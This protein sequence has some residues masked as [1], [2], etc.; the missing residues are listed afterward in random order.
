MSRIEIVG[1]GPAG[2]YVAT[3]LKRAMPTA[4]VRVTEQ[5][6]ADATHG[7]GV[8]FSDRA[9]SFLEADDPDA[10][11][12]ITPQMEHWQNMTLVH[13]GERV[14]ID[15]VGFFAIGRL[16]LL[17]IMQAYARDTGVELRFGQSIATGDA[18]EGDLIIGA[19]GFHSI[20]RRANPAAFAARQDHFSNRFAW[21]GTPRPFDTLTQTFV[22]TDCGALNAH[23]YRY[24]Q[25]M[26]TFIVECDEA[27]FQAHGFARMD[28]AQTA[29][30][31]QNIF[32]ETLQG[33]PLITN[34]SIWRQFPRLWCKNWVVGNQVLL[35]DAAHTAHFSVGSGTRLAMEDAIALVRA[36]TDHDDLARGLAAFE[37]QRIPIAK[38][39][40]DA[41]NASAQ[42]YEDFADKMA[43]PPLDFAFDYITRSGRMNIDRLRRLAPQFMQR[44]D[45]SR[46]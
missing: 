14:I 2:L 40:V 44:Y 27:S 37:R 1:G 45:S 20:I 4:S 43:L 3:L 36:L 30:V 25:A 29:A 23:H 46:C 42:W 8:V 11:A 32:G 18:P 21:F 38:K 28:E 6:A 34:H 10:Y 24:Q 13:R 33:A 19:D 15:G 12:T 17:Q 22:A 31:C 9:L 16:K 26:S 35:G 7:F 5:N 41:A 39:I